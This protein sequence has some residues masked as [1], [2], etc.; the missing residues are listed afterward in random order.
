MQTRVLTPSGGLRHKFITRYFSII[1]E[2]QFSSEQTKCF[3]V[4]LIHHMLHRF[5]GCNFCGLNI[6]IFL[7][8][9]DIIFLRFR[10][11]MDGI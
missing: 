5:Y 10:N 1:V 7:Y 2:V 8:V 9:L 3:L 4:F 6:I 11:K